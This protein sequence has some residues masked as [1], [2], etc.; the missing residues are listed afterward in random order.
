MRPN[1]LRSVW[2][3]GRVALNAWLALGSSYGAEE[4]ANVPYDTATVDLQHGMVDF[5]TA[6]L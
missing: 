4:I 1:G 5:E 2:E 3:N 6:L